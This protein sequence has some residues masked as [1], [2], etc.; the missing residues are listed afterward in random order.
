[1]KMSTEMSWAIIIGIVAVMA[2]IGWFVAGKVIP[3]TTTTWNNEIGGIV[4]AVIGIGVAY[5]TKSMLTSD[6]E[7]SYSYMM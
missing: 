2:A 3:A 5:F 7:F 4:G 1:M 6:D